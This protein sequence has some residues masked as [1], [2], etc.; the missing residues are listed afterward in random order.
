MFDSFREKPA[1]LVPEAYDSQQ[2]SFC[3][4]VIDGVVRDI[5]QSIDLVGDH[6]QDSLFGVR[7][8]ESNRMESTTRRC[9]F[10]RDIVLILYRYVLQQNKH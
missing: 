9:R 2:V 1:L 8:V 7:L 5:Q 3:A 4:C 6:H 10:C